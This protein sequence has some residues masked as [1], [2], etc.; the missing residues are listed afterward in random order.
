MV[1]SGWHVAQHQEIRDK[2]LSFE[3]VSK[4]WSTEQ[5]LRHV[6]DQPSYTGGSADGPVPMEVDSIE[7]G[8]KSKGKTKGKGFSGGEWLNAWAY[9]RGRGRG[10]NKGKGKGKGKS[11]REVKRKERKQG[12]KGKERRPFKGGVWATFKLFG[13]WPLGQGLSQHGELDQAGTSCPK[14]YSGEVGSGGVGWGWGSTLTHNYGGLRRGR[15][16]GTQQL[17]N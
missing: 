15:G 11:K 12:N 7:K 13:V 10:R 5:V 3:R 8:G 6:Q 16:G 14:S 4:I 1:C 9:G 17:S 2:V